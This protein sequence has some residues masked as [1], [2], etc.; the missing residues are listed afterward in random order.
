MGNV[1]KEDNWAARERLRRVEVLL[2]WR[3]WVGRGDLTEGFGISAAQA[4]GDLQRYGE[5]NPGAMVYHTSRKRYEGTPGMVCVLHEP[6]FEEAVQGILGATGGMVRPVGGAS[7]RVA[8]CVPPLRRAAAVVERRVFVALAQGRRVRVRYGSVSGGNG[9]WREFAP[10]ALGHD[11]LRW[12]VRAWCMEHE[13]FRDFVL[14]RIDEADWPGGEFSPPVADEA[15][16][17]EATLVFEANRE[18]EEDARRAIELDYGMKDGRLE[19]RVREAMVEYCL[20]QLRIPETAGA[21][22]RHLDR[23]K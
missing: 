13:D 15:W 12:H 22:L 14:S 2:W 16:E 5:L 17:R 10:Q 7:G 18:L 21:R 9:R 23:V 11:G 19:L 4:S 1:T 20:A 3:G 6:S 8:V